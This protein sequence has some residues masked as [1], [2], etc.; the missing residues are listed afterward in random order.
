EH[1]LLA[2][3]AGAAHLLHPAERIGD[4]PVAGLE[5]HRLLPAI[6]DLDRVRPEEIALLLRGALGQELGRHG[7][8]DVAGNNVIHGQ[9]PRKPRASCFAVLNRVLAWHATVRPKPRKL[10]NLTACRR[11]PASVAASA[12][13]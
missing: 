4:A 2:D 1:R 3:D 12:P 9:S 13:I 8:L 10:S 11:V 7:D 5:L 6:V